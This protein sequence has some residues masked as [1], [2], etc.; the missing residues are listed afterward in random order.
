[1]KIVCDNTFLN[2]KNRRNCYMRKREPAITMNG[3]GLKCDNPNCDYNDMSI[4]TSDYKKYVNYPCPKCGANLLTK[5][6]Y[7]SFKII[8][9]LVRVINFVCYFIPKKKLGT[10][11][12]TM[13]IRF[14][15]TGKPQ[16]GAIELIKEEE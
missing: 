6:D 7:R 10:D 12:A 8:N 9:G 14:D 3:G 4:P 11:M 13:D 2:Y 1:M 16:A 5:A 15:G